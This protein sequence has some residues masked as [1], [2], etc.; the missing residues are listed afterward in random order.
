MKLDITPGIQR[1]GV[2]M[3]FTLEENWG[4]DRWGGDTVSYVRPVSLSGTYMVS[5]DT[6]V[7]DGTACTTVECRCARCL[8][9]TPIPVE[10]GLSEAFIRENGEEGLVAEEDQYTYEG[11]VLDLT[12]AVRVSVLLEVP[13]RVLCKEDCKGL[14]SQCGANLNLTMCS[15]QKD[16]TRKSPFSALAS[17]AWEDNPSDGSLSMLNQDEE[18]LNNGSPKG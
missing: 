9:P 12:E 11:H 10:A 15:C 14:C 13:V 4:E 8:A 2:S 3:P 7:I 1:K 17:M 5:G 6:V 18:V 16:L